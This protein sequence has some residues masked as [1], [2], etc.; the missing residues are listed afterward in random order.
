MVMINMLLTIGMWQ[1]PRTRNSNYK[2]KAEM[3][4]LLF[5]LRFGRQHLPTMIVD[6]AHIVNALEPPR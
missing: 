2:I 4:H 3:K 5:G 1:K 6:D